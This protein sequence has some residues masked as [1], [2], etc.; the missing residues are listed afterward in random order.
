MKLLPQS[1]WN[2]INDSILG[3]KKLVY[4]LKIAQ[5]QKS[6]SGPRKRVLVLAHSGGVGNAVEATPL[7]QAIR[8]LWPSCHLTFAPPSDCLFENW[9]VPDRIIT[10]PQ[11]IKGEDFDLTF[12]AYLYEHL[13]EWKD[14]CDL[15]KVHALKKWQ[16]SWFL[17][18]ERDYYLG[19]L[20]RYGFSGNTP[21]CYVTLKKPEKHPPDTGFRVCIAPCG[22]NEDR[23]KYKKW[24]YYPELIYALRD[25]YPGSQ[26]CVVGTKEDDIDIEFDGKNIVDCRSI[27]SLSETAWLLRHSDFA[28]GNDCGPMHLA[29][30]VNTDSIIIFG[31]TCIIKNNYSG[32]SMMLYPQNIKCWPCQYNVLHIQNCTSGECIR[33][34]TPEMVLELFGKRFDIRA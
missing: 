11:E 25:Q 13:S 29:S 15:G 17:K 16:K 27:Y 5:V 31:P 8:M 3:T 7:V 19:M 23:W 12:A 1:V 20:K 14:H 28:I 6:P 24:P 34:V 10:N 9:C 2:C 21:P 26:I 33:S 4:L 22:R 18:P 32:K 30:A